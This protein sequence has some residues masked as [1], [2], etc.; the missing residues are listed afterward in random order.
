MLNNIGEPLRTVVM[1][2]E[3]DIRKI[4]TY[5]LSLKTEVNRRKQIISVL[6]NLNFYNFSFID[7][8]DVREKFPYWVGCGMTH[9]KALE[10]AIFPCIILEDDVVNTE[11]YKDKLYLPDDGITYLGLSS[12]GI[13]NGKSEHMGVIF[14]DY[15]HDLATVKY[16]TSGHAIYY[17]NK[18]IA[19]KFYREIPTQLFEIGKPFD[20]LYAKL[21]ETHKTYCL[22]KPL[23]FQHCPNNSYYTHFKIG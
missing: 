7:S 6:R 22:K 1:S 19:E 4:K 11:W 23:F 15:D 10:N 8:I 18:T 14:E 17:P 20:E 21:Q 9:R 13:K 12:W 5:I 2:M 3:I 16:M